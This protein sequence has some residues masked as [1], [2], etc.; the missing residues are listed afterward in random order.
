MVRKLLPPSDVDGVLG[1]TAANEKWK[2]L[3][4]EKI[5]GVAIDDLLKGGSVMLTLFHTTEPQS[6]T[7]ES[8]TALYTGKLIPRLDWHGD[9]LSVLVRH[10]G[11]G[12][13]RATVTDGTD[14]VTD[15]GTAFTTEGTDE[16]S[17]DISTLDDSVL[18]TFTVEGKGTDCN[19][20][21]VKVTADPVNEFSPPLVAAGWLP[22]A[23]TSAAGLMSAEDKTKLDGL[24]AGTSSESDVIALII[25]L[26]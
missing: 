3:Y 26:S 11:T 18:W 13:I 9:T 23:T 1:G 10:S 17:L 14:T 20:S 16:L 7:E 25:A 19:V 8:Y 2:D 22:D 4:T 21:R 5:N 6:T 24:G 15:E 12:Q